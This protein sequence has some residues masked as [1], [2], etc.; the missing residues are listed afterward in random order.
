V[1]GEEK[2]KCREKREN[3]RQGGGSGEK[4]GAREQLSKRAR[5]RARLS[6]R[7]RER[8][9]VKERERAMGKIEIAK[10]A[11]FRANETIERQL[12][13]IVLGN[14]NALA[15]A[16]QK[17]TDDAASQDVLKKLTVRYEELVSYMR[18]VTLQSTQEAKRATVAAN[19]K[20]CKFEMRVTSAFADP[21]TFG[22]SG[23]VGGATAAASDHRQI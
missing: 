3:G 7:E 17:E 18:A 23:G 12:G 21:P 20:K 22:G 2:Q 14:E 6:A 4:E 16:T 10:Q 5:G 13:E 15:V 9:C 8:V 19:E 1:G 11:L